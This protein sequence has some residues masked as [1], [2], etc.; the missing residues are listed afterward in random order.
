[1]KLE[2]II[3]FQLHKQLEASAYF[4]GRLATPD[5]LK[6]TMLDSPVKRFNE[7]DEDLNFYIRCLSPIPDEIKEHFT[8]QNNI[9]TGGT[10]SDNNVRKL[11][12]WMNYRRVH[13]VDKIEKVEEFLKGKLI[14]F[15]LR[16]NQARDHIY[17]EFE[18]I[19]EELQPAKSYIAIPGPELKP[20][21]RKED[22]E[23]KLLAQNRPFVLPCYPNMF[24]SPEFLVHHQT[25]YANIS[26]SPTQNP[27][28]YTQKKTEE[29]IIYADV[30]ELRKFVHA[31]INDQLYFI[32]QES[33]DDLKA[34]VKERA[35]RLSKKTEEIRVVEPFSKEPSISFVT[36]KILPEAH[37]FVESEM[38][39]LQLLNERAAKRNLFYNTEDLYSFHTSVKTNSITILG[40]MAGTGKSQLAQLYG[41]TMGLEPGKQLLTVPVY[42]SYNEP[43]DILGYLN[44]TTGVFHESETGLTSL[45]VEAER[46]P[47]KMYMVIFEEMNLSQVEYWFSPFITLLELPL[48]Q[49]RLALFNKNSHCV[50][51][52]HHSVT[53]RDNVLFIGTVNFDETTKAFSDRLL[54]RTNVITPRKISFE[55][56]WEV[57]QQQTTDETESDFMVIEYE[58][59][60]EDWV[61]DK[62]GLNKLSREELKVLDQMNRILNE[63]DYQ[64]GIS[65]RVVSAIAK[66]ISNIPVNED[67]EML[68]SRRRAFDL[69][70]KQRI[71]TKIKG[72]EAFVG[73][74]VGNEA[75]DGTL[76]TYLKN[77]EAQKVSDFSETIKV[78]EQKRKEL[79]VYGFAN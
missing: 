35:K 9:L 29:E 6:Y 56:A 41:E 39:F 34:I 30:P 75:M 2:T 8:Y 44:P 73:P 72:L 55:Q 54:D 48:D 33:L 31:R 79:S 11:D 62:V 57:M 20:A 60:R 1:M 40:G 18:D 70:V 12:E 63:Q 46:H 71:T 78:L 59:M 69:Q 28:T 61:Q 47:D 23:T 67:G 74:L 22:F 43:N 66:Y 77:E 10:K 25:I 52:Y 58:Q 15:R 17:V 50:N 16:V 4:L 68:I 38:Q 27:T 36:E 45:L 37:T 5:E 64:K 65:F 26:I 13:Y 49:R 32:P 14:I 21:E 76:I 42:P 3:P 24:A 53:I 19:E 51:G 7:L